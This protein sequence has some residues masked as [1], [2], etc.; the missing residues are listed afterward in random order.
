MVVGG[1]QVKMILDPKEK[2][3]TTCSSQVHIP[4]IVGLALSGDNLVAAS[5]ILAKDIN[6]EK[7]TD[8][9]IKELSGHDLKADQSVGLMFACAGRGENWYNRRHVES[10]LFKKYFPSSVITGFFCDGEIGLN[11]IPGPCTIARYYGVG[12]SAVAAK[13][14]NVYTSWD[15]VFPQSMTIMAR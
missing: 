13:V 3:A 10:H 7:M 14:D 11:C 2:S 12:N 15:N 1:G 5:K 4:H 6:D 9:A 8:W